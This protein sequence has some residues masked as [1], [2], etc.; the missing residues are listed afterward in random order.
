[1]K[2]YLKKTCLII[3]LLLPASQYCLAED[4]H[5]NDCPTV[6]AIV[7]AGLTNADHDPKYPT[8]WTVVNYSNHFGTQ[9]NW[10]LEVEF[11][12]AETEAEAIAKG[13]AVLNTL[14]FSSVDMFYCIYNGDYDGSEVTARAMKIYGSL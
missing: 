11:I 3:T 1:M 10:L 6:Q 9:Y 2:N 13:N 14:V 8:A 5:A 12:S 7:A 4:L